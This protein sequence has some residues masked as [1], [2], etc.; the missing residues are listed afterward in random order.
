[1]LLFLLGV[2]SQLKVWKMVKKHRDQKAAARADE[3]Q[4]HSQV[5]LDIGRELEKGNEQERAAWE[6]A[7]GGQTR[8][9]AHQ[10]DSGVGTGTT[11]TPQ[12]SSMSMHDPDNVEVNGK[13]SAGSSEPKEQQPPSVT[14]RVASEDSIYEMPSATVENLLSAGTEYGARSS[15]GS[16]IN[17]VTKMQDGVSSNTS[18]A[19]IG[20]PLKDTQFDALS[21]PPIVPLPFTVSYEDTQQMD[22]RSSIATF[23]ASDHPPSRLSKRFSRSSLVRKFPGISKRRS[24]AKTTA[25]RESMIP[26]DDGQTS[27]VAATFDVGDGLRSERGTPETEQQTPPL[28]TAHEHQL[29]EPLISIDSLPLTFENLKHG[30]TQPLGTLADNRSSAEQIDGGCPT[31]NNDGNEMSAHGST[32]AEPQDELASASQRGLDANSVAAS[33]MPSVHAMPASF[34][35]QLPERASKVVMAYRTN[36]WAKHLEQ[37]DAPAPE[38]LRRP[39]RGPGMIPTMTEGAAPVNVPQLTQTSLT[40]EP[41]PIRINTNINRSASSSRDSLPSQRHHHPLVPQK[42]S[43]RRSSQGKPVS[44]TPS[45]P[46]LQHPRV[47][48][49]SSTPLLNSPL[50]DS[51]IEEDVETSFPQRGSRTPTGML[52]STLMG[53]RNNKLQTRYSST[54]LART[55]SSNSLGSEYAPAARV[56]DDTNLAY[57]R[58]HLQQQPGL[59]PHPKLIP[60]TS[61]S[62][63]P[64]HTDSGPTPPAENPETIVS[65]WRTSLRHDASAN[66]LDQ[67]KM[68]ARRNE[69]LNQKRRASADTQAAGAERTRMESQRSGGMRTGDLIDRH[70]EAMRRM[71]AGVEL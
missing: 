61:A 22:D 11:A 66:R 21:S 46:S 51:P 10:T 55:S 5:E 52:K 9:R 37:A 47:S 50:V 54:S 41:S 25:E 44:R 38:S 53:Q 57:R 16:P 68:D 24:A 27:S 15:T 29:S 49:R 3:E 12:K 58:S 43:L 1:V 48:R 39:S 59:P 45:Q 13:K 32:V 26:S 36:E 2:M 17:T 14:V 28:E 63:S 67:Q 6:V 60:R 7:Y 35:D 30:H 62:Y 31:A 33:E 19:E 20:D 42:S 71:Q 65:A 64:Y 70:K 34:H 23:A 56:P 8:D 4:C 40:A 18:N 69:L